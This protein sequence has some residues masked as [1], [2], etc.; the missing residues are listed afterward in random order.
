[1]SKAS[2]YQLGIHILNMFEQIHAAGYV[3]NDLKLDNLITNHL[4]KLPKDGSHRNVFA[5]VPLNIIDFGF[6]TE[7][8]KSGHDENDKEAT[9]HKRK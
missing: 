4:C 1:M 3:Y 2:C 9:V 5:N 6:A 8:V 7:Y